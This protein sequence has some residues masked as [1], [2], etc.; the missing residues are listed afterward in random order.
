MFCFFLADTSTVTVLPPHSSGIR[1]RSVSSRLTRSG[2]AFGL[3]ILLI[4]TMI[5]TFGGPGVVDRF[6]RLRHDAVVGGH[7]QDDDVGHLGAA[8]AHAA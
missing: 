7:H 3:S 5:G 1:S 2:L 8:G 6:A 4:A